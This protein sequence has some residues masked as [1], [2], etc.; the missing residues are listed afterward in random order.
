MPVFPFEILFGKFSSILY[1]YISIRNTFLELYSNI[2][3][4]SIKL[5]QYLSVILI[6]FP[7]KPNADMH[8]HELSLEYLD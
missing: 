5:F 2:G 6:F 3:M 8:V 1:V 7:T 4:F